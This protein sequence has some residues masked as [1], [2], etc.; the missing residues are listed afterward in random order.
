MKDIL[1]DRSTCHVIASRV[2]SLLVCAALISAA[3]PTT[4]QPCVADCARDGAVTVDELTM[5]VGIALGD[6][7]LSACPEM[8]AD[9][10]ASVTVDDLLA[11]VRNA[12]QPWSVAKVDIGG[13]RLA[14]RCQGEGTPVVVLDTGLGDTE[15][16]WSLVQPTVAT[17]TRVCA[18]TRAGIGQSEAG[19]LPRSTVQMVSEL[20]TLVHASCLAPP[21]VL[22]GHSL[23]SFNVRLYAT[24]YPADVAG[25][26]SVDGAQENL[27]PTV[28]QISEPVAEAYCGT[29][30]DI[31]PDG[32]RREAEALGLDREQV[33]A[34]GPVP[35]VP[36]IVL[37][38]GAFELVPGL[39]AEEMQAVQ[40]L[41]HSLQRA[42]AASTS[43][44]EYLEVPQAGHYIQ[45]D[46][47]DAV[48]DAIHRVVDVV[49]RRTPS[50]AE[51][52]A[53]GSRRVAG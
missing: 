47:P 28:C 37:A 34:S 51:R 13:Y 3:G 32:V 53:L 26:V 25:L 40:D 43:M 31:F 41:W 49:P 18:Y 30:P 50:G 44:S 48:I 36:F 10:D 21:Y 20:H 39:T 17:F 14:V 16:I 12:L 5:G 11:G 7:P 35:P 19:P 2:V 52:E 4:A 42:L 46:R 38:R 24:T 29:V 1:P 8:D 9:H 6:R 23:G 27:V 33:R 22:V 45:I 15:R